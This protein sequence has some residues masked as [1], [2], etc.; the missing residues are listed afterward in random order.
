MRSTILTIFTLLAILLAGCDSNVSG[1]EAPEDLRMA[2]ATGPELIKVE[3]DSTVS[4]T[5]RGYVVDTPTFDT[6]AYPMT[7]VEFGDRMQGMSALSTTSSGYLQIAA[8]S[9]HTIDLNTGHSYNIDVT[10]QS[11]PYESQLNVTGPQCGS[12]FITFI[13]SYESLPDWPEVYVRFPSD[14]PVG[15]YDLQLTVLGDLNSSDTVSWTVTVV[16][17]NPPFPVIVKVEEKY[18][19]PFTGTWEQAD[20]YYLA[21]EEGGDGVFHIYPDW[22]GPELDLRITW[23]D[24]RTGL[25]DT[26]IDIEMMQEPQNI[27]PTGWA[28]G[29]SQNVWEYRDITKPSGDF[30]WFNIIGEYPDHLGGERWGYTVE[31]HK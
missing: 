5:Y 24:E 31:I 11:E 26:D 9:D 14:C 8:P 20:V 1:P 18:D 21:S 15:T 7:H 16:D 2:A 27:F 10:G 29:I 22:D 19:N 30:P 12:N 25:P 17:P 3:N 6:T 4:R 28:G 23:G 13:Q